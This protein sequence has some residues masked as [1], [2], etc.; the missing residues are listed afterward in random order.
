MN[1]MYFQS[2]IKSMKNKT[3]STIDLS[4]I[5][6]FRK[7][8]FLLVLLALFKPV[9]S[10]FIPVNEEDQSIVQ[11]EE[12]EDQSEEEDSSEEELLEEDDADKMG[13]LLHLELDQG[14]SKSTSFA[15]FDS[16]IDDSWLSISLPPPEFC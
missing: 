5:E 14:K 8:L 12:E 6:L 13:S 11:W 1:F 7:A 2:H 9:C 4:G 16:G 15:E 3:I 10:I